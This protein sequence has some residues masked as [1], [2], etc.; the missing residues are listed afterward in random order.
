M[1]AE[2]GHQ[3]NRSYT[4][5]DGNIHLNGAKLFDANESDLG[6]NVAFRVGSVAN[7]SGGLTA[8]TTGLTTIAAAFASPVSSAMSS[9]AGVPQF[10]NVAFSTAAGTLEVLALKY[11]STAG[12]PKV[13]TSTATLITWAA[14]GTI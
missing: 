10:C 7:S 5:Q 2:T 9:A 3:P 12:D 6:G 8:I 4:D 1:A 11:T 14:F 13:A